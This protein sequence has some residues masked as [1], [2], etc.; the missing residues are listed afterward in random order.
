MQYVDRYDNLN[1]AFVLSIVMFFPKTG[2]RGFV[3]YIFD[4]MHS[5]DLCDTLYFHTYVH[6]NSFIRDFR[7]PY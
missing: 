3:A 6:V 4:S 1:S 5:H 2:L 7:T